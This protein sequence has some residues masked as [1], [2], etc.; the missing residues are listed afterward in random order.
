MHLL[1][2][3][4]K[5]Y[6]SHVQ[7]KLYRSIIVIFT[8]FLQRLIDL[9]RKIERENSQRRAVFFSFAFLFF[10]SRA[11][12]WC[13]TNALSLDSSCIVLRGFSGD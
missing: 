6:F 7:N 8:A 10:H 2:V 13:N 12:A 11:V 1:N 9:H 5:Y 3:K 4:D